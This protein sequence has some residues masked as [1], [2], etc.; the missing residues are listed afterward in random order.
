MLILQPVHF[1]EIF[2]TGLA[3]IWRNPKQVRNQLRWAQ[4]SMA[5]GRSRY[6]VQQSLSTEQEIWV[7]SSVFKVISGGLPHLSS[8][9]AGTPSHFGFA[10]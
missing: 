6:L 5:G 3:I 8:Q 10:L 7:N 1:K 9:Q 2:M 4:Q